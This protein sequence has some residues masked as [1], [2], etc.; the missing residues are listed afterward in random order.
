V[1]WRFDMR[2]CTFFISCYWLGFRSPA[3]FIFASEFWPVFD[4]AIIW[5]WFRPW[6]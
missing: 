4:E 6:I 3:V 1:I 5:G 2:L